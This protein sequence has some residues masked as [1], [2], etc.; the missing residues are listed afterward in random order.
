MICGCA[1]IGV[2]RVSVANSIDCCR[3]LS[4][5]SMLTLSPLYCL[6]LPAAVGAIETGDVGEEDLETDSEGESPGEPASSDPPASSEGEGSMSCVVKAAVAAEKTAESE[7]EGEEEEP[8]KLAEPPKTPSQTSAATPVVVRQ[9]QRARVPTK[10]T[11]P[12]LERERAS[13]PIGPHQPRKR[14]VRCMDCP[15]CLRTEDCGSCIFCRDKPKFGGPGV[16]KQACM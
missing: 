3:D 1:L 4:V 9:S 11:A 7:G 8:L 13:S 6:Y 16:K 15:A 2:A 12:M 10:K 14:G 5:L